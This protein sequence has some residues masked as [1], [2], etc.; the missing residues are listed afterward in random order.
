MQKHLVRIVLALIAVGTVPGCNGQ[1]IHTLKDAVCCDGG[2]EYRYGDRFAAEKETQARLAGLEK[3]RQR[4][5]DELAAARKASDALSTRTKSLEAQLADRDREIASLRS[6]ADAS[7]KMAGQLSTTQTERDRLAAEL[8]ASQASVAALQ[9]GASDKDKLAA[10][11]ASSQSQ[12]TALQAGV[13]DK[14]RLAAE[15]AAAQASVAALQAGAGDRDKLAGELE[16]AKKRIAELEAQLAALNAAEADRDK[17]AAD[18][19]K[20]AAE[21]AA[22][23]QRT[24]DLEK[25]VADRD[26]QLASLH[27]DLSA[28]MAKLK[29]AQRGLVRALRP[30]IEKGNIMVDLNNER[31]LINLASGYLFGSGEDQ[32]K[33]AGADALKQVGAILKDFPE[34]KVSVDG[35]TDNR[36]IKNELKKRFPSNK[37]LSEA[38]AADAALALGEGGL[39]AVTT[40]GYADG[41]PVMP[42]TTDAGRAKNRRVEV[43]VT[44]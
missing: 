25:Q 33:P 29:E 30:Q 22:A 39:N 27:G 34:Y 26:R 43:L 14:D 10:E 36:P 18:K 32:L 31:L 8:A 19:D 13:S 24:A 1:K 17:L 37:E 44:K 7:S 5:T 2:Y 40:H 15:L 6:S 28:E 12:V 16:A 3:D 9:A 35:H 4:L 23:Q 11:L 38:R 20:L 41:R 21:L 42:N